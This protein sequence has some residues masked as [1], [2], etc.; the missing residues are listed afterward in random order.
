MSRVPHPCD[1]VYR[2]GGM[3]N[4]LP[5][6]LKGMVEAFYPE[7]GLGKSVLSHPSLE[8]SEGW[9]AQVNIKRRSWRVHVNS[10]SLRSI[11]SAGGMNFETRLWPPRTHGRMYWWVQASPCTELF[12][13]PSKRS[14][15]THER[16]LPLVQCP[17]YLSRVFSP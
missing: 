14:E 8:K 15:E 17:G 6:S 7:P 1:F 10:V 16:F 5:A 13:S 12:L 11:F 2:T 4:C 3:G 9:G